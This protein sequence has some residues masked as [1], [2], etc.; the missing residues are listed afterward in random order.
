MCGVLRGVGNPIG[1][2]VGPS[3]DAEELVKLTEILNPSNTMG[4]LT[5]LTRMGADQVEAK[6][7]PLTEGRLAR[8]YQRFF[9]Y[10]ALPD[11]LRDTAH[12]PNTG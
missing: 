1:V 11:A 6:L 3:M 5:L 7:P 10:V 12:C 2:K 9:V 4:R 8:R